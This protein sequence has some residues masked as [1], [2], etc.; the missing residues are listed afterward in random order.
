MNICILGLGWFGAKLAKELKQKHQVSGSTRDPDK[1]K[2]FETQSINTF[3]LDETL[4][5]PSIAMEADVIVLNIPPFSGQLEWFKSWVMPQKAHIIFISSTSVY[6]NTGVLSENDAPLPN[7]ETGKMIL[8]EENWIKSFSRHTIIRFGG[9]IGPDRHPG[10]VLSG[11]KNLIS[12]HLAVNLIHAEDAV[13][14]TKFVIE[15]KVTGTFNLVA[16][17]HPSRKEYYEAYCKEQ[18]LALPEFLEGPEASKIISSEMVK[19]IYTFK[20]PKL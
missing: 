1:K 4:T 10:K 6:G 3:L 11:K 17:Y 8:S 13:G 2:D 7:T 19:K 14:F 12:G 9:L 16:P 20:R 18:G 5:P 15:N